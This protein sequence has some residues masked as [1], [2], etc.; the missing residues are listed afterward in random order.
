M[1][2]DGQTV[3]G[4]VEHFQGKTGFIV[5]EFGIGRDNCRF[6]WDNN[7]EHPRKD[8]T[9]TPFHGIV[10]PDGHPWSVDDVKALLG[11]E[12]FAKGPLFEVEYFKDANFSGLAK[13]SVTPMIDFDLGTKRAPVRPTR[14]RAFPRELFRALDGNDSAAGQR[15]IRF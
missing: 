11:A 7:R 5:W 4:V 1:N 12:G 6:T 13:K 8:E 15:E 9:P 2:R 14:R 3:P 10:Y